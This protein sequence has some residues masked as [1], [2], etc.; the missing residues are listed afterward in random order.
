M[1]PQVAKKTSIFLC[2][3]VV[4]A[5]CYCSDTKNNNKVEFINTFNSIFNTFI[6]EDKYK[7][8]EDLLYKIE[9]SNIV[10]TSNCLNAKIEYLRSIKFYYSKMG[11]DQFYK[12]AKKAEHLAKKCNNDSILALVYNNLGMYYEKNN[13]NELAEKNY[14]TAIELSN[15]LRAPIYAADAYYNFV[16]Y[17]IKNE[18]WEKAEKYGLEA[19]EVLKNTPS[20]EDRLKY[21]YIYTAR[22]QLHLNK[23]SLAL[24]N[25]NK[26]KEIEKE[27]NSKLNHK[28]A[29]LY[30]DYYLK[31]K[32]YEN[33]L[34][35]ASKADHFLQKNIKYK[36]DLL[37]KRANYAEELSKKLD[38]IK[39]K[40]LNRYKYTVFIDTI[41]LIIVLILLLKF[42]KLYKRFKA[43]KEKV[44][45]LLEENEKTMF[46][47]ILLISTKND[48]IKQILKKIEFSTMNNPQVSTALLPVIIDI[49]QYLQN[50]EVWEEFQQY[51]EK[52]KPNFFKK[53]QAI[54]PNLT[55]EE[56]KHCSYIAVNLNAD[57]VASL[58][59][60]NKQSIETI[61]F[62]IKKKLNLNKT[63]DL[64]QYLINL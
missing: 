25:L 40:E 46:S 38:A 42:Y 59:G 31:L 35:Y 6:Q 61:R 19:I 8:I 43:K 24:Q 52:Y 7:P 10:F 22:S 1:S 30:K 17:Y 57:E 26:G 63:E 16:H 11:F 39:Q 21:I 49:Q 47:K 53:L 50:D 2:F 64:A 48:F 36:D 9:K 54:N 37:N 44:S 27:K 18:K 13:K 15:T 41:S 55:L 12:H 45:F 33:A 3:L 14:T 62:R 5:I 4:L 60:I 20:K 32:D 51:F 29:L 58:T 56:L 23:D 34:I 28:I